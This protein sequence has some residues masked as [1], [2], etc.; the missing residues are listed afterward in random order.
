M[1]EVNGVIFS[2]PCVLER[3]IPYLLTTALIPSIFI[4]VL[5]SGKQEEWE[6][7]RVRTLT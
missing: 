6:K 3:W 2:F 5:T 4:S 7:V 1:D